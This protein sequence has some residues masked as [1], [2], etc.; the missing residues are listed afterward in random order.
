MGG[1][2]HQVLGREAVGIGDGIVGGDERPQDQTFGIVGAEIVAACQ[3]SAR[4]RYARSPVVS[5]K[6][7]AAR[8][9]AA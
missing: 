5:N 4:S 3:A 6:A 1:E 7:S 9:I 8:I 2:P